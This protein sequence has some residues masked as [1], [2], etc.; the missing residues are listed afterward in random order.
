MDEL[1]LSQRQFY[2][3]R[4]A[5]HEALAAFV[6][7]ALRTEAPEPIAVEAPSE[8]ELQLEYADALKGFRRFD[9]RAVVLQAVADDATDPVTRVAAL[10]DL[11]ELRSRTGRSDEVKRLVAMARMVANGRPASPLLE[12]ELLLVQTFASPAEKCLKDAAGITATYDRLWAAAPSS[13]MAEIG[14]RAA[15][16]LVRHALD[17]GSAGEAERHLFAAKSFVDRSPFLR[18]SAAIDYYVA[19][20]EAHLYV[21]GA[22]EAAHEFDAAFAIAR[23]QQAPYYIARVSYS[24]AETWRER[25]DLKSA[26]SHARNARAL[27]ERLAWA[28]AAGAAEVLLAEICLDGGDAQRALTW[29]RR[30]AERDV[31]DQRY[32]SLYGVTTAEALEQMGHVDEAIRIIDRCCRDLENGGLLPYLGLGERARAQIYATAKRTKEAK[33]AIGK[34]I[35]L[36]ER[37]NTVATRARAYAISAALARGKTSTSRARSYSR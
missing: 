22:D 11:V 37:Y 33:V 23:K 1:G 35:D 6:L 10:S 16:E 21:A 19:A 26:E 8:S 15:L 13:R 7:Q 30:A 2:R 4:S 18:P 3:E 36:L 24:L 9:E 32:L 28:D 25:G 17:A 14:V 5:A 34:A 20:G 27:S 29:S 12:A 31:R